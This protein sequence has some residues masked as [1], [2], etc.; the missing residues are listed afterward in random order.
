MSHD[1]MTSSRHCVMS[2]PRAK[3]H[4][5]SSNLGVPLKLLRGC[6]SV[7]VALNYIFYKFL[8][9]IKSNFSIKKS[10]VLLGQKMA[11]RRHQKCQNWYLMTSDDLESDLNRLPAL[12]NP[13]LDT[14]FALI[15]L[16][17]AKLCFKMFRGSRRGPKSLARR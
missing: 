4:I 6:K 2:Y 11:S 5:I 10:R 9:Q 13:Y 1:V 17:D 12:K 3:K 16:L 8:S 7:A 15:V 14:K